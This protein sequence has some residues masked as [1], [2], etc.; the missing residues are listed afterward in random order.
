MQAEKAKREDIIRETLLDD[1]VQITSHY[2]TDPVLLAAICRFA[3]QLFSR[4]E[5]KSTQHL[6]EPKVRKM[7]NLV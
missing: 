7:M 2:K 5:L 1:I 6:I 3:R 4:E